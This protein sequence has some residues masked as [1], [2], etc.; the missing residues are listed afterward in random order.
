MP[1][2]PPLL[3]CSHGLSH[4]G[5]VGICICACACTCTYAYACPVP[6]VL[7]PI[8]IS[9]FGIPDLPSVGVQRHH[10]GTLKPLLMHMHVPGW[11]PAIAHMGG[12]VDAIAGAD[13]I[14]GDALRPRS[15]LFLQVATPAPPVLGLPGTWPLWPCRI[16]WAVAWCWLLGRMLLGWLGLGRRLAGC[17]PYLAWAGRPLRWRLRLPVRPRLW[18]HGRLDR[19]PLLRLRLRLLLCC[20]SWA[21]TLWAG[22][23]LAG[24]R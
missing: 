24:R 22:W 3:L 16:D 7:P 23:R 13:S 6:F 19:V 4:L 11:L 8:L 5:G 18:L 9:A 15:V 12:A 2:A 14:A 10:I 21:R 20:C 17:L 1:S